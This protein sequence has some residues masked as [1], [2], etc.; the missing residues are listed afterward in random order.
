MIRSLL[1]L[2]TS[3]LGIMFAVGLCVRFQTSVR[4]SHQ[5]GLLPPSLIIGPFLE[6]H[7]IK[8]IDC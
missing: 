6:K 8:K 4:E 7:K 3:R 2:T 1:Y 5:T